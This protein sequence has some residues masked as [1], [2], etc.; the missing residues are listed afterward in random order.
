MLNLTVKEVAL[1]DM[2]FTT[3]GH[4]RETDAGNFEVL[5]VA[6]KD[7]RYSF[8]VLMHELTEWAICR[9]FG[10]STATCDAFDDLWEQELVRGEHKPE[11]EAGFDRRCP[12]RKG[13]VWG[14]RMERLFC[15]LLGL[16]W[17]TYCADWDEF[18][19]AWPESAKRLAQ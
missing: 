6:L 7:W 10:V 2:P 14:A 1:A 15:F 4:W 3:A 17:K 11:E 18:F 9:W 16:R 5:V 8:I 12:Y 13:H 19:H